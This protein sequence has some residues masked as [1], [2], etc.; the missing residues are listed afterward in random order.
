MPPIRLTSELVSMFDQRTSTPL[1]I[2]MRDQQTSTTYHIPTLDQQTSTTHYIR[3]PQRPGAGWG[4]V[5][6]HDGNQ[7]NL[8]NHAEPS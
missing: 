1:Y 3:T 8:D 7:C 6:V 2:L 4:G 5:E